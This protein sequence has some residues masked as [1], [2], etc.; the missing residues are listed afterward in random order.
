MLSLGKKPTASRAI[1]LITDFGLADPYVGQVKAVLSRLAP[2]CPVVDICHGVQ[3]FNILQGSFFLAASAPHF[4]RDAVLLSVVDPG[5]GS[6][7]R[8]VVLRRDEQYFVAPDN[9]LL[10]LLLDEG[11]DLAAHDLSSAEE[12]VSK[13]SNTFHG[14]DVFAPITAWLA[15]GGRP[16]NLGPE[17][18]VDSLVRLAGSRPEMH[19]GR[20]RAHVLHV[21]H[22]GN[23]VLNLRA[24]CLGPLSGLTIR[25]PLGRELQAVDTYSDLPEGTPG[26]LEGSQGFMEIAVNRGSAARDFGLAIGDSVQLEWEA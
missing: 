18:P 8:I 10:G 15:S 2:G 9:G 1:G 13:V 17:I 4:S 12:A 16:E 5:V 23:C 20:A 11:G 24:G 7:R 14:R 6:D 22:F 3:P 26:L 25:T 19:T 21:D